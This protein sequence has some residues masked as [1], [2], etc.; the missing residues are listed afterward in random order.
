MLPYDI[1]AFK[2]ESFVNS[3]QTNFYVIVDVITV[4]PVVQFSMDMFNRWKNYICWSSMCDA[5]PSNETQH[6]FVR[7]YENTEF[8]VESTYEWMFYQP[9][10]WEELL[11]AFKLRWNH[12]SIHFKALSAALRICVHRIQRSVQW[13][14]TKEKYQR[15]NTDYSTLI[16]QFDS[17]IAFKR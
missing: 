1:C 9:H 14:W 16:I 4:M 5:L 15:T 8:H 17:L 13:Q 10:I 11:T 3:F 2:L 6:L 12:M 7:D